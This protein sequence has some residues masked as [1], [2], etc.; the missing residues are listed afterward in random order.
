MDI[1]RRLRERA[2]QYDE[3]DWHTGIEIEAANTIESLYRLLA[4]AVKEADGWHD[5][6]R[7]G[8]IEDDSL[9]DEARALLVK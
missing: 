5:E 4:H 7:G 8:P 3:Y 1:V 6:S 2:G 9:M